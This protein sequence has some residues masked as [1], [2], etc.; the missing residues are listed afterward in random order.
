MSAGAASGNGSRAMSG[1][2][3]RAA[4][5]NG[6]RAASGNDSRAMTGDGPRVTSG[7]RSRAIVLG[8]TGHAGSAIVRELA[9]R[10]VRVTAATRRSSLT[11]NLEGTGVELSP[12]DADDPAQIDAWVEG[13][14]L[15]IDAAAPYP[16]WLFRPSQA[17]EVDPLAY[18]EARTARLL[19]A[20]R[21]HGAEL[22]VVGS[23]T[24]LPHPGEAAGDLE[25]RLLRRMHP[26][27]A[28]KEIVEE[29]VL[30]AAEKGLPALV[31]NPTAFLGPWDSKHASMCVLPALIG[32]RVPATTS[33]VVNVI[34]VRDMARALVAA[35]WAE[36]FGERIPLAGHDVRVDD[37]AARACAIAGVRA[38][39][40]RAST[41]VGAALSYWAEAAFGLAGRRSPVPALPML[42]VRYSYPMEPSAAQRQLGGSVRSLS[43]TLRDAIAW[44]RDI[45]YV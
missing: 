7:H 31:V 45:G 21:R 42:L 33:R 29:R 2:G 5:G 16:V 36:R 18:A 20:V 27:F 32:G 3:S 15:V 44:Y 35:V 25:P 4:S 11:A 12:G 43:A 6:S 28:V 23:F 40:L 24:T 34:D 19:A 37:L 8:A 13:H 39:R 10:G 30:R 14:D 22:A 26:Y 9:A 1:N 41:R 38:P 17:S